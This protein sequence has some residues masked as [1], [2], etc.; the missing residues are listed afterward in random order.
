MSSRWY[1]QMLMEEF[2]PVT[3]EQLDDLFQDGTLSEDDLVRSEVSPDWIPL[4][5]LNLSTMA[6]QKASDASATTEIADLSELA[7]EF[8]D[9]GPTA[10]RAAYAEKLP[11]EV[12]E[13]SPMPNVAPVE[14]TAPLA[15]KTDQKAS[16]SAVEGKVAPTRKRRRKGG[17][18]EEELLNE[19]FDDVFNDDSPPARRATTSS[20]PTVAA[21][22]RVTAVGPSIPA[23]P[24]EKPTAASVSSRASSS[25]A[26]MASLAEAAMAATSSPKKSRRSVGVN[27]KTILIVVGLMLALTG[28]YA[29]WQSDSVTIVTG[30]GSFD[31]ANA[32]RSINDAM[33]RYKA[34]AANPSE[35][36]WQEFS[37]RTLPEMS[38]LY[39]SI[40]ERSGTT[41][42]GVLCLNVIRSLIRLS[43]TKPDNT[44]AIGECLADFD[45]NMAELQ[46]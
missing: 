34:I 27:P 12:V 32:L 7:F 42:G 30:G 20:D 5:E 1:Y 39:K 22:H 21:V 18:G 40:H 23:A 2:G 24:R 9:S 15:R 28:G 31:K 11:E 33:T 13:Q 6:E 35:S 37:D 4:A 3:A 46:Q 44:T 8:E 17:K 41:H 43:G 16:H 19:I 45:K 38:A 29:Y 14:N 10:R 26:T 36:D 25:S